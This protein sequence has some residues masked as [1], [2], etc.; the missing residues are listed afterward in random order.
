MN[1]DYQIV[2]LNT[3]IAINKMEVISLFLLPPT[4]SH[5]SLTTVGKREM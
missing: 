4:A 5:H 3:D 2:V 1:Y